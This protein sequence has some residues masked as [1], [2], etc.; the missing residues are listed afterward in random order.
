MGGG[1]G[2]LGLLYLLPE[3]LQ[4]PLVLG[5]VLLVLL[6]EDLDEVLHHPL[7]EVLAAQVGVAVGG[8]HLE[9]AVVDRQQRDLPTL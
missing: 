4:G 2:A 3:L 8:H 1:Q 5:H 9:H 6:V 7:V